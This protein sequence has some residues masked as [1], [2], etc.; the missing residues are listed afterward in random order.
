MDYKKKPVKKRAKRKVIHGLCSLLGTFTLVSFGT[1]PKTDR[2]VWI[3]SDGVA[4][5]LS[6]VLNF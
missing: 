5:T 6:V 1:I 2:G 4:V 3:S